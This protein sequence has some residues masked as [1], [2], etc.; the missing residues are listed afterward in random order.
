MFIQHADR[1]DHFEKELK[2]E[3]QTAESAGMGRPCE[4]WG[5]H[6]CW[7]LVAAFCP[8]NIKAWRTS[9]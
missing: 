8:F 6:T 5:G 9:Q 2:S 3:R 1:D 7:D 4:T